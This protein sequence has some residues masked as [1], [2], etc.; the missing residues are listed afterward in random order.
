MPVLCAAGSAVRAQGASTSASVVSQIRAVHRAGQTFVTWRELDG[1]NRRYR[2]YR[3]EQPLLVAQ[4]LDDADYLGEVDDRSSRN[5][6][7]S[8]ATGTERTWIIAP[9]GAALDA[10]DGLFVHTVGGLRN[11]PPSPAIEFTRA[12]YAVTCVTSGSEEQRIVVGSNALAR[13]VS[14]WPAPPEPVVQ[15]VGSDGTLFAHWTSDRDTPYQSALSPWPSRGY[16]YLFQPGTAPGRHGLVIALHAAGQTYAQGW[17]ARFETPSDV[18]IL[19]PSDLVPFT[20]WSFWYGSHPLLPGAAT[21]GTKILNYTQRRVMWTLDERVAALGAAH[22]PERV[23]VCGGSMGALGGMYLVG[24]YPER[25]A[26]ALLRN[27]L[28]DLEATDYRNPYAFERIFGTFD[29]GLETQSGLSIL[30]RTNASFMA[31]Y[32]PWRD[33][34]VIRTLNGRN[35]ETVGWMS[36]VELFEGLS[37][38]ARPAVHYFDERT[39]NPNG[40]WRDLERALLGRTFQTRRDRPSLRFDDCSLDDD[41][42]NGSRTSG[43][44]VGAINAY[45]EYDTATASGNETLLEYDVYLRDSGALDDSPSS[46]GTVKMTPCRT[47]AFRPE[48]GEAVHYTLREG[49]VLKE[50]RLLFA[51]EHGR[52]RTPAASVQRDHREVRFERRSA[53]TAAEV[54]VGGAPVSGR[55]AQVVLQGQPGGVWSLYLALEVPGYPGELT[56]VLHGELDEHG[57]VDLSLRLPGG[58]PDR[59]SFLV[60]AH[61]NGTFTRIYRVKVQASPWSRAKHVRKE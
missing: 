61:V 9:G 35:D 29:L 25:F 50:E 12:Y 17:P 30:Q 36:A 43:D 49:N 13:P 48:P 10:M 51:D 39:H 44:E 19:R 38:A 21:A 8:L 11:S 40:Y 45:V 24:E 23:Y 33:W 42:G 6:G 2:V 27:G 54:F 56:T 1:T 14:E 20:G 47:G 5:Q 22:D 4:D 53:A 18:D 55:D 46:R 34:P 16:N 58:L 37:R 7:R 59:T 32:E 60:R 28:Y 41:A 3:S 31:A 26:A 57:R 52:V 15:S